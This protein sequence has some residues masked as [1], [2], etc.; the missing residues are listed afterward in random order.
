MPLGLLTAWFLHANLSFILAV[1]QP[2]PVLNRPVPQRATGIK[3]KRALSAKL[4]QAGWK[5]VPLRTILAD[6]TKVSKVSIVLD[7]R[8]DPTQSPELNFKNVTL[9]ELLA[10]IAE[11]VKAKSVVVGNV[12]YIGPPDAVDA[13]PGAIEKRL[14]ALR[15]LISAIPATRRS[16][17]LQRDTAHWNDLDTPRDIVKS[18]AKSADLKVTGLDK[19]PHDLWAHATIPKAG[20]WQSLSLVLIQFDLTFQWTDKAAGIEIVPLPKRKKAAK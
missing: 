3:F 16:K 20:L 13:L 18:I 17:L 9:S 8:I 12:V 7:G 4:P 6:L 15:K 1:L 19:V 2:T 5:A 11:A 14:A 10:N